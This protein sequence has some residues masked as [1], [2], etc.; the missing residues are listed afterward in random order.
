MKTKILAAVS[1]AALALGIVG[2]V[3]AP[4]SAHLNSITATASCSNDYQWTIDWAVTNSE[5]NRD[6]VI[7]A[8]S[9][10]SVVAL[11]SPVAAGSTA[12]FS[13]IVAS[14]TDVTLNLTGHWPS[15][16]VTHQDSGNIAASAFVGDCIAP[17]PVPVD[18]YEV[19]LYLYHKT[20]PT[21]PASWE[22]SGPQTFISSKPSDTEPGN[23][24]FTQFPGNLPAEVCGDG[25]AV[26]Q[27]KVHYVDTW[28]GWPGTITYPNDNIGWPP[29]YDAKHD[30]LST[31]VEVPDCYKP[32]VH[33]NTG[34][35]FPDGITKDA[36]EGT[37]SSENVSFYFDNTASTVPVE[38]TVAVPDLTNNTATI[39]VIVPA[40]EFREIATSPAS[41]AG[42]VH[43]DVY[44]DGA[45]TPVGL[46]VPMFDGCL[47]RT[48]GDPG[49]TDEVCVDGSVSNGSITVDGKLGLVYTVTNDDTKV[50]YELV[51]KA[52]VP[53][54]TYTVTVEA[55][56]GFILTSADSWPFTVVIKAAVNCEPPIPTPVVP[57]I[58]ISCFANG[59]YTLPDVPGITWTVNNDAKLPGTYF[60]PTATKVEIIA[61][62]GATAKAAV[63]AV[64]AEP[65]VVGS[66]NH[67][68]VAP[69]G[70]DLITHPLVTPAAVTSKSP[71]CSSVGSYTVPT[72]VGVTYSI[73]GTTVAAGVYPVTGAQSITVTAAA[74][75]PDYGLE[76]GVPAAWSLDFP[77]RPTDCLGDL[78]T[79]ALTGTTSMIGAGAAFGFILIGA[80][81]IFVRRRFVT[82]K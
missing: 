25:W 74:N 24:W 3:A 54:G 65:I 38:F 34:V 9:D 78:T 60:V 33:L 53:A 23:T 1:T 57:F 12:H 37:F 77:Q 31:L 43:Y 4:A 44:I 55:K 68:F 75:G 32:T 70:C 10:E 41:N 79:L 11:Q 15:D 51:N 82:E 16:N 59:S 46:D 47:N 63:A 18:H 73:G 45:A 14:P 76:T 56:A 17:P 61:T 58:G 36:P 64:A 81:G 50:V 52:A 49:H 20:D 22:N 19:A 13:Q 66:W 26:Q 5:T 39:D 30:D 27:D 40:G 80:A 29:I 28:A 7:T 72:T 35:C 62:Y 42:L 69:T 2:V 71:T 21:K 48:P 6:E 67:T 8:S